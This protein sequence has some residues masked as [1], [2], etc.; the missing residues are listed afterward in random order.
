MTERKTVRASETERER[1]RR[2]EYF[3]LPVLSVEN[4]CLLLFETV[5]SKS[6]ESN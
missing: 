1:E 6:A 5:V 4:Y 3:T 2:M